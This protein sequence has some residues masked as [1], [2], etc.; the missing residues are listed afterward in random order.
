MCRVE[1]GEVTQKKLA[2]KVGVGN[3]EVLRKWTSKK[4]TKEAKRFVEESS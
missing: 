4:E 2:K 1:Y 3:R